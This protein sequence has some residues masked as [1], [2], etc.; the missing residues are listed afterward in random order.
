MQGMLLEHLGEE[1]F[2]RHRIT[3]GDPSAF[4]GNERDII[5]LSMI[6]VPGQCPT[7]V[8]LSYEQ[9]FNVAMTRARDRMYLFR[10]IKSEQ[11]SNPLDLKA[12]IIRHFQSAQI[13]G[14]V[15]IPV[16]V[17]FGLSCDETQGKTQTASILWMC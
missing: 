10:S 15:N 9:R 6:A 13:Q 17:D 14:E 7:Q 2:M 3:A 8:G 11:I 1:A 12:T 4:Q 5:M 16:W